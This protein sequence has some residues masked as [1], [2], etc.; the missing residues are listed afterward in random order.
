MSE[1]PNPRNRLYEQA[2]PPPSEN[3][4][5]DRL[6][7]FNSLFGRYLRD[8]FGVALVAFALMSLLAILEYVYKHTFNPTAQ[9]IE[10]TFLSGAVLVFISSWLTL[11]FGLGSL[12]IIAGIGYF[13]YSL[14]RRDETEN[15]S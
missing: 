3:D 8:M 14:L 13:G 1:N 11:W 9:N 12:L 4:W 10:S 6:A 15:I 2:G 7:R 5:L